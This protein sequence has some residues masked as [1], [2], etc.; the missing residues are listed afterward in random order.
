MYQSITEHLDELEK[1]LSSLS[2][3]ID[4]DLMPGEDDFSSAFM[5][6]QPLNSCLFPAL[7][8]SANVT[9]TTNPHRFSLNELHF[10]GTS[11]QNIKDV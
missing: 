6:Q 8:D 10:L 3:A 9:P 1:F 5:P 4:V 11:G 2:S 7:E